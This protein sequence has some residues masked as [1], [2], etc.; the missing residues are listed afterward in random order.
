MTNRFDFIRALRNEQ[1]LTIEELAEKANVSVD[2]ISRLERG[3]RN[4]ISVVRLEKIMNAFNLELGDIFGRS[5]LDDI[6]DKFV[7][8]FLQMNETNQRQ[9]ATIFLEIL[10]LNK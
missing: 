2:L 8:K 9:Y 7:T 10:E 3:D 6:S 4:D 1:N 5:K